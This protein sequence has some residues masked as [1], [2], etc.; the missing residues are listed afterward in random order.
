MSYIQVSDP[1][2]S[3]FHSIVQITG[4]TTSGAAFQASGVMI[5]N[6]VVLTAG[7]VVDQAVLSSIVV[8]PARNGVSMPFGQ[9]TATALAALPGAP[10]DGLLTRAQSQNDLGLIAL[11]QPVGEATGVM[12]LAAGFGGGEVQTAGYPASYAGSEETET[13]GT[14]A[15][16]ATATLLYPSGAVQA[17]SSG[18]PLWVMQNGQPTVVG[19]VSTAAWGTRLTGADVDFIHAFVQANPPTS[20]IFGTIALAG[21][22]GSAFV[23]DDAAASI[24]GHVAAGA[25]VVLRVDGG[26]IGT[27]TAD[28][29]GVWNAALGTLSAGA[30]VV[31]ASSNGS[32]TAAPTLS[33]Y[34]LA[35]PDANG[36]STP[37]IDARTLNMLHN[38]GFGAHFTSNTEAV[39]LVDGTLNLGPDTN[40]AFAARLYLGL[41]GRMPDSGGMAAML[42]AGTLSKSAMSAAVLGSGEFA[43]L[44]PATDDADFVQSLYAGMLGRNATSTELSGWAT[45]MATAG[46]TRA[47]IAA[48]IADTAEA[49]THWAAQTTDVWMPDPNAALVDRLYMAGLDRAPEMTAVQAGSTQLASGTDPL[50][51]GPQHRRVVGIRLRARLA[52]RRRVRRQPVS[53][54][55]GPHR[56]PGRAAILDRRIAER[57]DDARRCGAELRPDPRERALPEPRTHRVDMDSTVARPVCRPDG[58]GPF[59]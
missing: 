5:A 28:A 18:S 8:T 19:L 50:Q 35:T 23:L 12:A 33:L 29:A 47:N 6:N 56:R 2:Q 52:D 17:G 20:S 9:E 24:T 44:H 34:Q 53:G 57:C 15:D 26:V 58:C 4:L 14:V 46:A 21:A 38:S 54:N 7:H 3:V 39:R 30:H 49:K 43:A 25:S 48:Q 37:D 13:L 55:D 59:R 32:A 36:I 51:I 22:V 45:T 10:L 11:A 31:T 27:A 40:Q 41:L 1:A 42:D 16:A